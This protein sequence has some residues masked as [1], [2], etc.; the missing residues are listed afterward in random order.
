[1]RT[2]GHSR[3]PPATPSDKGTKTPFRAPQCRQM[4]PEKW[5]P[6]RS[7]PKTAG[8]AGD[9]VSE[10]WIAHEFLTRSPMY[11]SVSLFPQTLGRIHN[12]VRR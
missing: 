7:A 3:L 4:K 12:V 6:V 11:G 8:R 2:A 10:S 1:M 5:Q 9:H